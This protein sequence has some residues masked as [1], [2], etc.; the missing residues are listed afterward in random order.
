[1][2]LE[3]SHVV[4]TGGAGGIGSL[5]CRNLLQEGARVTVVDRCDSIPF[6]ARLVQGDL[7]TL[8]GVEGMARLLGA[9]RV[10]I[11][12]NLAGIQ[13][14]GP[15][16]A[17]SASHTALVYA[18]NLVAPVV[19]TQAVLPQMKARGHGHI[20]NIGSTFGSISFA[21]FATYSS[22]KAGVRGFSEALRREVADHGI[23]VTY[24]APRAVKTPINTELVM[25]LA[26][27]I[28]MNMDEPEWV[29]G[30]IARAIIKRKKDVYLGFPEKLFVRI[31]ALLPRLVDRA[32]ARNDTRAARLF[33]KG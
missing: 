2:R 7:S 8:D 1:M 24:I 6:A 16:E 28:N 26:R 15:C 17:Q 20:V 19:L 14:F 18:V 32:L 10:D 25:E 11:L 33:E 22:S 29:A 3:G 13:Y 4:V 23:D 21:H 31:N 27:R 30:R 9:E 12:V 5:L